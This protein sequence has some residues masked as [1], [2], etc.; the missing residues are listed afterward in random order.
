MIPSL[1]ANAICVESKLDPLHVA[2]GVQKIRWTEWKHTGIHIYGR[3]QIAHLVCMC[4]FG[5]LALFLQNTESQPVH[6]HLQIG[7]LP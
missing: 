2:I 3:T 5:I 4:K 6:G 1:T 7:G